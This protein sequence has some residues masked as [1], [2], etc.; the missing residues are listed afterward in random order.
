MKRRDEIVICQDER[1][2]EALEGYCRSK[3][4]EREQVVF[5]FG[6]KVIGPNDTVKDVSDFTLPT[7]PAAGVY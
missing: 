1:L 3:Q 5:R 7:L 2:D 4:L 6:T